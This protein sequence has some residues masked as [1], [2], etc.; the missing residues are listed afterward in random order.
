[1][2]TSN[3]PGFTPFYSDR[4]LQPE[5]LLLIIEVADSTVRFDRQVKVPLY[6]SAGIR[7]MGLINL[8]QTQ[9][10]VY[11]DPSNEGYCIKQTFDRGDTISP[12][13]FPTLKLEVA[14]I[15]A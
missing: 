9:I 8:P 10:E 2:P 11:R 7:E 12:S 5:D 13:A 3:R 1:M 6:A 4:L 15:L 14:K